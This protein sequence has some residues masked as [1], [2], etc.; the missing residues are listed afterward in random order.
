MRFVKSMLYGYAGAALAG[1][2]T[3]LIALPLGIPVETAAGAAAPAG[4]AFG[5]LGLAFP[6]RQEVAARVRDGKR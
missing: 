6:W 1:L 5:V 2:A 3:A 4:V